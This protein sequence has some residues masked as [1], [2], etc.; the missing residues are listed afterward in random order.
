MSLHEPEAVARIPI[1][2]DGPGPFEKL[3]RDG[4]CIADFCY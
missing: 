3:P 2:F 1:I 4:R